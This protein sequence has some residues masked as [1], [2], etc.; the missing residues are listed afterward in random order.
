M[1]IEFCTILALPWIHHTQGMCCVDEVDSRHFPYGMT[2][3]EPADAHAKALRDRS[4]KNVLALPACDSPGLEKSHLTK[5]RGPLVSKPAL[6]TL[7]CK[8]SCMSSDVSVSSSLHAWAQDGYRNPSAVGG[9]MY[10][11]GKSFMTSFRGAAKP[12]GRKSLLYSFIHAT[13][14]RYLS[15]AAKGAMI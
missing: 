8:A 2:K 11:V 10:P 3:Q 6:P 7:T 14:G 12:S 1:Y 5:G 13:K 4:R 9:I 15:P